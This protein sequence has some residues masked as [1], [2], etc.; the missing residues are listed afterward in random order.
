[1]RYQ[2]VIT[3]EPGKRG[4]KPCTCG[5]QITV[6]DVLSYVASGMDYEEVL[7][8]FLYVTQ[9]DI[10]ACLSYAGDLEG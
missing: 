6:Y 10:L 3:I 7:D 8:D 4:G 2:D 1:M 9:E 5:M